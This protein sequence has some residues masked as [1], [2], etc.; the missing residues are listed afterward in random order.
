M[1]QYEEKNEKVVEDIEKS[2]LD[3]SVKNA[4]KG[5]LA[6]K[7]N[8]KIADYTPGAP[9]PEGTDIVNVPAGVTL[10]PADVPKGAIVIMHADSSPVEGTFTDVP[11]F[12]GTKGD[13]K[14]TFVGD[15]PV[16][17]ETGGGSDSVTTGS[18]NDEIAVTG[19]GNVT[20]NAGAGDDKI[21]IASGTANVTVDGGDGFDSVVMEGENRGDHQFTYVDGVLVLNSATIQIDKDTVQVVEFDDGISIIADQE[22]SYAGRMYKVL[23]DREADLGGLEFWL[24]SIDKG[25]SRVDIANAFVLSEEFKSTFGNMSNEEFLAKLYLNMADRAADA[26]G[27]EFWMKH[28]TD[29]TMDRSDVARFFAES[30]EA[31]EVMGIDGTQY[32]IEV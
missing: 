5:V 12:V 7:E 15:T 13:D 2:G 24:D 31:V 32:V 21:V 18:G 22:G 4:I 27:H 1:A 19:D 6:G 30:D 17:V 20:V 8:V 26:E 16:T 25:M 29:G 23:F 14:V 3:Q 10:N 9:V 11:V 28:L